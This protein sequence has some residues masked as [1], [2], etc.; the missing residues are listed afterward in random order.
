M[1]L[2]DHQGKDDSLINF[3]GGNFEISEDHYG[4]YFGYYV[5]IIS[6]TE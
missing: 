2:L 6:Y 4:N 5:L 3:L 1:T